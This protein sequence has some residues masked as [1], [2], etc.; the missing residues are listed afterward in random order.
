MLLF[1]IISDT[2]DFSESATFSFAKAARSSSTSSKDDLSKARIK[3]YLKDETTSCIQRK[4]ESATDVDASMR[5][6][7]KRM[8]ILIE[9]WQPLLSDPGPA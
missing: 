9:G 7:R 6:A 1:R 4:A 5:T 8:S 3:D 2:S